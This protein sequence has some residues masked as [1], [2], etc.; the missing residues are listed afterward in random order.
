MLQQLTLLTHRLAEFIDIMS[1][2]SASVC[3][4]VAGELVVDGLHVSSDPC[5]RGK[6]CWARV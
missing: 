5:K 3:E 4:D 1:E 6:G 2:C